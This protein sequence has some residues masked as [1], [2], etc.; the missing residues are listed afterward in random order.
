MFVKE[1]VLFTLL[2]CAFTGVSQSNTIQKSYLTKCW[3]DSREEN[4]EGSSTTIYRPCDFK[5]FPPSRFRFKVELNEGGSCKYLH[6]ASND[7]H[8]MAPGTWSYNERDQ[9]LEIADQKGNLI[10]RWKILNLQ[11]DIME[12]VK[13]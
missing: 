7:A 10:K 2:I 8:Y 11:N 13:D 3:S 9:Y 5:N 4:K 1:Y 12:V 6:L